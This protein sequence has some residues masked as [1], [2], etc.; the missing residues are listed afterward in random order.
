MRRRRFASASMA[1]GTGVGVDVG[2]EV[3]VDVGVA[4]GVDVGDEVAV[5]LGAAVFVGREV[6]VSV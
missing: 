2:D 5:G 4:V 6:G 3:A 1:E